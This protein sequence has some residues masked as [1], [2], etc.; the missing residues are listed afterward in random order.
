MKPELVA[1]FEYSEMTESGRIRKPATC[2]GFREDKDPKDVIIPVV[3]AL[4]K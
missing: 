3:K 1:N 2:K 4:K